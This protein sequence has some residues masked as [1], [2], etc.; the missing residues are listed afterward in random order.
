MSSDLPVVVVGAGAAGLAAAIFAAGEGLG[1]RRVILL[2][3][4]RDGGRKILVSGGGRCNVLPSA[5]APERFVT[6][7]SPNT[8]RKMLLSWPLAAST[9]RGIFTSSSKKRRCPRKD[10]SGNL[11]LQ[12]LVVGGGTVHL[13]IDVNGYLQVGGEP[14]SRQRPERIRSRPA[15]SPGSR[16]SA[17]SLVDV[18]MLRADLV[19][20]PPSIRAVRDANER[21]AIVTAVDILWYR[22][23]YLSRSEEN[24]RQTESLE[25]QSHA[26]TPFD[27]ASASI[28]RQIRG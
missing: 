21:T 9:A 11:A 23:A 13:V 25:H 27:R 4:T 6:D 2:E 7:L 26:A 8:L 12:C 14:T 22:R 28:Q 17:E 10:G 15:C 24:H 20:R 18:A 5:A 16:E 3:R 1:G 19:A